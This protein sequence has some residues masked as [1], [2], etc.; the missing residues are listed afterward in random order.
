MKVQ[1]KADLIEK[2]QAAGVVRE[3]KL[4]ESINHPF[5]VRLVASYQDK[6]SVYMLLHLVQGGEL[7]NLMNSTDTK[8]LPEDQVKFYS[9]G[10]LEGLVYMHR[11]FILYRDLKPEN[12]MIDKDGYTVIVDLGFAKIVP[13]KTYTLCGTPLYLAPEVILSRGTI[14][15][16]SS[17]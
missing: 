13:D 12:V 17:L 5:I 6:D 10:I 15:S 11:R 8:S 7:Y 1:N 16:F 4:M 3:K 2:K 9:A 14:L